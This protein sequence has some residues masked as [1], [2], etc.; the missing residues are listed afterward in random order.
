MHLRTGS[1]INLTWTTHRVT[2]EAMYS[3]L[4]RQKNG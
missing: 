2:T 1:E 4:S 3:L